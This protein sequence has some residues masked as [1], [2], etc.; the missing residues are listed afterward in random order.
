M[1][2]CFWAVVLHQTIEEAHH[3]QRWCHRILIRRP[4][5]QLEAAV[6][7]ILVAEAAE[8]R[9]QELV[10]RMGSPRV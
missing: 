1:A 10:H 5:N 2:W 6:V 4:H 8:A 3:S 9:T 7:D